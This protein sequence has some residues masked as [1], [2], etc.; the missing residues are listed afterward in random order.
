MRAV[1]PEAKILKKVVPILASLISEGT[2]KATPEGIS[3]VAMDPANVAMIILEMYPNLF[4]EYEV[5][6]EETFTISLD[7]LKK[8]LT[9]VKMK[10]TVE[11]TLDKE[12]N[13]F[14]ITFKGKAKRTFAL[15]LIEAEQTEHKVPQLDLPVKIELDAKAMK[16]ILDA[17]KVISDSML[18]IADPEGP[19]FVMKAEG[20]LR[21][22]KVEFTPQ[23]ETVISMEIPEKAR[24]RYAVDYLQKMSKASDV[25]DTVTIRFKTD[26]PV[27]MDYKL[28]DKLKLSFILAPRV[29]M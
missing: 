26:Y 2:F 1:L 21:E 13:R 6:G 4:L 10:E 9:K 5:D 15:P 12:K 16:E 27:W 23:D 17:A 11:M 19:K 25:S 14:L 20:E 24:A 8:I 7:D 28:L 3:L 22:M 29:E 18:F